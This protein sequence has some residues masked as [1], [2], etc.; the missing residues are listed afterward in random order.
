[1]RRQRRGSGRYGPFW[2]CTTLIFVATSI[3]TFVTYLSHKLQNKEWDYDIN[4]LTWSAGLFYGYV[5]IVPLYL[6]VII[7]YFSAPAGIVQLF[8]LYGYSLFIFIPALTDKLLEDGGIYLSI[9]S[10]YVCAV[11][12]EMEASGTSNIKF[13]VNGCIVI[14]TL[15]GANVEKMQE[16]GEENFIIFGSQIVDM[17]FIVLLSLVHDKFDFN[18]K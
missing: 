2:I 3:G 8:C 13:S 5:L 18:I 14:R 17:E 9:F 10:C 4:L 12:V 7:K 15:D 11:L 6:Y 16:V 1:M